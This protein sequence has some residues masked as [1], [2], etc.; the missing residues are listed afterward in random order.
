MEL[1]NRLIENE[2]F[3][4]WIYHPTF[5]I[6]SFWRYYLETMVLTYTQEEIL[7]K[8]GVIPGMVGL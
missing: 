1:Y 4:K 7:E 5:E 8:F 3:F 6:E 2:L